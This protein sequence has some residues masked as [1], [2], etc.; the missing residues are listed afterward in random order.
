M[1]EYKLTIRPGHPDFLDLPWDEPLARW[2]SSR[3]V[4]LPKGISRH[5]V[6]FLEYDQGLYVVKE[7]PSRAANRDYAV[8][9][10]LEEVD[11]LAVRPVGLVLHRSADSEH[12]TSAALLTEYLEHSF[13]YREL[14]EGPGFGIRREQ[15]LDAFAGLLVELHVAGCFWGDCSLSNVLYR[16]DANAVD[17]IMV[18]AE[19][20]F[21]EDSL[22]D[23]Q[24]GEDLRIMIENVAGGMAD[25]AALHGHDLDS[26]DLRLSEDIAAR[27]RTLWD[28]IV[29]VDVISPTERHKIAERIHRLNELGF[30][31]KEVDLRPTM[32]GDRLQVQIKPGSRNYHAQRLRELTGIEASEW[33]AWQL[34]SDLYYYQSAAQAEH[35]NPIAAIEWRARVYEPMIDRLRQLDHVSNPVQAFCDLLHHRYVRSDE[36]GSDIGTEAA[37][38]DWLSSGRPGYK[39]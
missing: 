28:E 27:Y 21:I 12:E 18:D 2:D 23:G 8:L 37:L 11:N 4:D 15:M 20:A 3:L 7:M 6:R 39:I 24:R 19:T 25:I 30:A 13:S 38:Q 17:T 36:A 29:H 14:L 31:V 32:S 16:F 5:E 1:A 33:Q 35:H 26:A 9:S 34:L 22:S 10:A